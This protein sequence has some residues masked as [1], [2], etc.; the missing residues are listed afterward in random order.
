MRKR[1]IWL[2]RRAWLSLFV[3]GYSACGGESSEPT[4]DGRDFVLDS[5]Q[6]FEVL[7]DG[8]VRLSFADG[9]LSFYAG[10]NSYGGKYELEGARLVVSDLDGTEKGCPPKN[11]AQDEWL[12]AFFTGSPGFVLNADTLT[13]RSDE[14]TL[15]FVVREVAEP[16]QPLMGITWEV[17]TYLEND[18]ASNLPLTSVPTIQFEPDGSLTLRGPCNSGHGSYTVS[19]DRVTLSDVSH[20]AVFCE[21]AAGIAD[22]IF[23]KTLSTGTLT[24]TIESTRLTLHH[25]ESGLSATAAP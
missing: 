19:G 1:P 5:T 10:C 8:T 24:F 6:G 11:L 25:G 9:R 17:D 18:A 22:S 3:L 14:A 7:D 15:V 21:G 16:D 4:V 2:L 12:S 20:S 23:Y 13:L